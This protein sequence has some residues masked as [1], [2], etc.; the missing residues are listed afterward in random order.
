MFELVYKQ[1]LPRAPAY[2]GMTLSVRGRKLFKNSSKHKKLREKENEKIVPNSDILPNYITTILKKDLYQ[3]PV[4]HDLIDEIQKTYTL[5]VDGGV[6]FVPAQ[7][8]SAKKKKIQQNK[9]DRVSKCESCT[10][11]TK[12]N[13]KYF[14]IRKP[15]GSETS[16]RQAASSRSGL[17]RGWERETSSILKGKNIY[18]FNENKND[19]SKTPRCL[20]SLSLNQIL[21]RLSSSRNSTGAGVSKDFLT[22]GTGFPRKSLR[23][24]V[25]PKPNRRI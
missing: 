12:L 10:I 20:S 11:K 14:S 1:N 18:K 8:M 23:S 17:G 9:S 3:G 22:V 24:V 6:N 25:L 5:D 13:R 15:S 4:I 21:P 7:P 19:N 16:K 2:L